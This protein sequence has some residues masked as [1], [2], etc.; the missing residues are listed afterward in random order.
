M[1]AAA[2]ETLEGEVERVTFE[3]ND[4]GFR[5]LKIAVEGRKDRVALVGAF[6]QVTVGA[7]VRARGSWTIDKKFG[8]QF[9]AASVTELRPST[10]EGLEKYLGSGV[11]K[12][13]GQIYAKRIVE[14][15][16]TDALKVLDETPERLR[17]VPGLGR[18]RIDAIAKGWREQAGMRE[19]MVFLEGHGA[20]PAL[21]MRIYKRY[22]ANTMNQVSRD[23][24]RLSIDVWGIGFKTADRIASALGLAK[25]SV[26]RAIAAVHQSMR[27][28]TDA[29][30]TS[31]KREDVI[32]RASALLALDIDA[33]EIIDRAIE[34]SKV[35]K[36]L[37]EESVDNTRVVSAASLYVA[38]LGVASALARLVAHG[39]SLAAHA[40]PAI[41]MF[42][43]DV[44]IALT[45]EQRGAVELAAKNPVCVLTGGP[46]VGKTTVVRAI[47]NLFLRAKLTVRL[48]APTGRAAKRITETTG[49]EALTLH[50]LL[51]YEPKTQTWKRNV[52]RPL[53]ADAFIVD[54][55]SM[56][57]VEMA[58]ALF[59]ALR[60]G[61]RL[62][63][64]GDVDQLPS[65]GPGAVLRDIIASSRVACV[66]LTLIHRQ[67]STSLIVTNAHRIHAGEPPLPPDASGE[68]PQ[69]FFVIERR[70]ALHTNET[71]VELVKTRIP[72]RFGLDSI[73]DVQVLTPMHR[74]DAGSLAL[75]A[76]LQS[77][78]NP[79]G[80]HLVRGTT[81]FRVGD[82]VMQLKNDYE[83]DVFNG[84]LG[85]VSS[86][87]VE[88]QTLVVRFDERDVVYES[89]NI[90]ELSLAYACTIHK[91]QGSEYPAVVIPLLSSH[92]V[93][94]SRNLLYTAVT[95]GRRLVVLVCDPRAV[96]IAL[97][98]DRKDE[99]RTRL[100]DRIR[101][102]FDER[103]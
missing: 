64:V 56:L 12:G 51:E 34:A 31:V 75:N 55:T 32:G 73:K 70:D 95:R 20:S 96:K 83:R 47:L 21:A 65:V 79:V 11:I 8:E 19:A 39:A 45:D 6:P 50:R 69:D 94:L 17:E 88:E 98:E 99:R 82:K 37:V 23:P 10:L 84:D 78:L 97:S 35:E 80:E 29:G 85:F 40:D 4:T 63:M 62:V 24:Y 59:A 90:D 43:R 71:I 49:M 58:A 53:E 103:G 41:E 66:R 13:V 2:E 22:G 25:D 3:N 52:E 9:R 18:T 44:S 60:K 89:G 102:A 74:G 77:V 26:E 91:S 101:R 87:D 92:F 100:A 76:S 81:M 86:V 14:A 68:G 15:F 7:R 16:G 38:E 48:A 27:D 36:L 30:H 93:M 61:A 72:R 1:S 5:V 54:E 57:D 42:E 46:G 33:T 67:K 28:A